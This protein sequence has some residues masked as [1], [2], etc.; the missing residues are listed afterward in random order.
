V[1]SAGCMLLLNAR[2]TRLMQ[3]MM[4]RSQSCCHCPHSQQQYQQ[5]AL[6]AVISPTHEMY[7]TTSTMPS[8]VVWREGACGGPPPTGA[9]ADSPA[10]H[11]CNTNPKPVLL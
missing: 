5:D 6:T 3:S 9:P 11:V 1:G 10:A 8:C 4:W 2:R 7:W